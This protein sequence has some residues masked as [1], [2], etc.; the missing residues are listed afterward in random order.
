MNSDLIAWALQQGMPVQATLW[1]RRLLK[2]GDP[3]A[4]SHLWEMKRTGKFPALL[5]DSDLQQ[6][7]AEVTGRLVPASTPPR[8][9]AYALSTLPTP[10]SGVPLGCVRWIAYEEGEPP[11]DNPLIEPAHYAF[12]LLR[13]KEGMVKP[14]FSCHTTIRRIDQPEQAITDCDSRSAELA[15]AL[16]VVIGLRGQTYEDKCPVL[17]ATGEVNPSGKVLKVDHLSHKLQALVREAPFIRTVIIPKDNEGQVPDGLPD[18]LTVIKVDSVKEAVAKALPLPS[19][20]PALDLTSKPGPEEL[21]AALAVELAGGSKGRAFSTR[22]ALR[23]LI[24]DQILQEDPP[25]WR[26]QPGTKLTAYLGAL[27]LPALPNLKLA[28]EE[29]L[30][31]RSHQSEDLPLIYTLDLNLLRGR[32]LASAQGLDLKLEGV[33]LIPLQ[34]NGQ[35]A[36]M[37]GFRFSAGACTVGQYLAWASK[38]GSLGRLKLQDRRAVPPAMTLGGLFEALKKSLRQGKALDLKSAHKAESMKK[39]YFSQYLLRPADSAWPAQGEDPAVDLAWQLLASFSRPNE[40]YPK[41]G[42]KSLRTWEHDEALK[43]RYAVTGYGI[44]AMA[45]AGIEFNRNSKLEILGQSLYLQWLLTREMRDRGQE[46]THL[47]FANEEPLRECFARNCWD[48][49]SG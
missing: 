31:W 26:R 25:G 33:D 48:F 36:G 9:G 3:L 23:V 47:F 21:K 13:L 49:I 44:S 42:Q 24:N 8:A 35:L 2:Q 38:R 15:A 27:N 10:G 14:G 45:H 43:T 6:W 1:L 40:D 30:I 32:T 4:R 7:L 16:G 11:R 29:I 22:L 39:P 18:G 17:A 28:S 34:T 5:P 41:G 37:L 19:P 12:N 46:P 20:A